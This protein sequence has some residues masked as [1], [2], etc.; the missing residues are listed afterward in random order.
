MGLPWKSG[1]PKTVFITGGGSGIGQ[2]FA[3]RLA[4]EGADIAIFNRKLAPEVVARLKARA[5]RPDQ[6]FESY[7]ADVADEA[8][9]SAAIE[10][11]VQDMGAPD[12]AINSAGIHGASP[13]HE[14]SGKEFDRVIA[15]NLGGSRNFAAAVLPHL[16]PGSHLVFVA[17]LAALAGSYAYVA[18]CASKFGVMGLATCL[19]LELKLRGIDVSIC[20]PGEI[21]TPF[22]AKESDSLHPISAALKAFAGTLETA[23]ACDSMLKRIARRQFEIVVGARPRASAFLARHFPGMTAA[24]SDSIAAKAAKK[25]EQL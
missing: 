7:S 8:G 14:L 12:L 15:V 23:P 19:R 9:L 6:K 16:K 3:E 1:P 24:I 22:L 5:K 4:A 10:R 11:A 20:C 13:F 21:A 18:Y 2:E 17:S 25:L